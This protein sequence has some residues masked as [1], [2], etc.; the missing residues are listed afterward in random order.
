MKTFTNSIN[1]KQTH[2]S[3]DQKLKN[4]LFELIN[5]HLKVSIDNNVSEDQNIQITGKEELVDNLNE[6]IQIMMMRE[7]I[8]TLSYIKNTPTRL[9][10]EYLHMYTMDDVYMFGLTDGLKPEEIRDYI[11]N[12][13][14]GDLHCDE[15][16]LEGLCDVIGWYTTR[17]YSEVDILK[18]LKEEALDAYEEYKNEKPE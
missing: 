2:Y 4:K 17:D 8:K 13:N 3:A 15:E 18:N 9:I 1:E 12:M 16:W 11:V 6:I 7:E 10:N 5:E 14:I